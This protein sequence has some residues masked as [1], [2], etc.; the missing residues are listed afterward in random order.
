MAEVQRDFAHKPLIKSVW[1]AIW[2]V[3]SE[4][5]KVP[6]E[7]HNFDIHIV[8]Q[9]HCN[10]HHWNVATALNEWFEILNQCLEVKLV[11][12][13][14]PDW[15]SWPWKS[16]VKEWMTHRES[17]QNWLR[18]LMTCP[19]WLVFYECPCSA[20][21]PEPTDLTQLIHRNSESVIIK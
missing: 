3:S 19:K 4:K 18:C 13:K 16:D 17:C 11:L 10:E 7:D 20:R 2:T 14:H 21:L 8:Q 9:C 12:K 6:R 5:G 1:S 15:S